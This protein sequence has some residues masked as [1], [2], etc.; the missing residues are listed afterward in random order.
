MKQINSQPFCTK[1]FEHYKA[2]LK[3]PYW[4]ITEMQWLLCGVTKFSIN[5]F[6]QPLLTSLFGRNGYGL[7]PAI[8]DRKQ[9]TD[10]KTKTSLIINSLLEAI[11]N[12][13]IEAV[14][15]K[16]REFPS[17]ISD[18]NGHTKNGISYFLEPFE[19]L[20]F[21]AT[22]G[23]NLPIELQCAAKMHQCK[24]TLKPLLPLTN[25]TR[26]QLQRQVVAQYFWYKHPKFKIDPIREII[27][28]LYLKEGF[29]FVYTDKR[30][31][32]EVR[33]LMP[34]KLGLP[35]LLL[36]DVISKQNEQITC[37]FQKLKI[38]VETTTRLIMETEAIEDLSEESFV[39]H[40]LINSYIRAG[41]DSV[42]QIIQ[43]ALRDFYNYFRDVKW[44]NSDD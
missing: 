4:T 29:K 1:N 38:I 27:N 13:L 28:K 41:G 3:L 43:L 42:K 21:V 30:A 33:D 17:N 2:Y 16:M 36:P 10:L 31:R 18:K 12:N 24:Q 39:I 37:D 23:F 19:A 7:C 5:A 8:D 6:M 9:V 11:D 40:P 34:S 14:P 25:I 15:F 22:T 32:K 20:K 44:L 35:V 26:K